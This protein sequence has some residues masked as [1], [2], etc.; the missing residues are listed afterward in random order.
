MLACTN[1]LEAIKVSMDENPMT[2]LIE[3]MHDV[4]KLMTPHL[5]DLHGNRILIS[6]NLYA[7]RMTNV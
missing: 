6:L 1:L 5:H 7:M 4:K 2:T 3:N